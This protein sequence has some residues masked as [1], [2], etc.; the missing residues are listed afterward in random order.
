MAAYF[1]A[2]L[3]IAHA[4]TLSQAALEVEIGDRKVSQQRVDLT[5]LLSKEA[6]RL[7]ADSVETIP[8]LLEGNPKTLFRNLL[9]EMSLP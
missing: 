3:L 7:R 6:L 4:F 1:S 9:I 8:T 2:K 5:R